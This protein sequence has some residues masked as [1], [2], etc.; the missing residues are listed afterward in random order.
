M[1]ELGAIAAVVRHTIA[2]FVRVVLSAVA[3]SH[4]AFCPHAFG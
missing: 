4:A 2:W 3:M 1:R